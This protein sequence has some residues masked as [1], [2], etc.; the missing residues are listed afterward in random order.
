MSNASF[1]DEATPRL[2]EGSLCLAALA[3]A[4]EGAFTLIGASLNKLVFRRSCGA[5]DTLCRRRRLTALVLRLNRKVH[6][7]E[8]NPPP[9]TA[10][11]HGL[12]GNPVNL[13]S[14][15]VH[16]HVRCFQ[17]QASE[18]VACMQALVSGSSGQG[19]RHGRRN[20][21]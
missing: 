16:S 14:V 12:V 20:D 15:S 3:A 21:G 19:R 7:V 18:S 13:L 6:R 17:V 4:S 1:V 2:G 10:S 8:A 5:V 11:D 9:S